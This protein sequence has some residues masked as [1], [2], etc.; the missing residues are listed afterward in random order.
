MKPRNRDTSYTAHSR[1]DFPALRLVRS[2][3]TPA[4][5]ARALLLMF[6]LFAL[7]LAF[8]P[9]Q[10]SV[11][12]DG[13]VIAFTPLERQ[14]SIQAPLEGRIVRWWVQ[15]GARVAAGDRLLEISDN[16]PQLLERITGEINAIKDKLARS[17]DRA[18]TVQ[19]RIRSLTESKSLGTTAAQARVQ[20]AK[21]RQAA[22]AQALDASRA[23]DRA[24]R[25]NLERQH[26]LVAEG[27]ASRR[28]DELAELEAAQRRTDV[29][30]MLASVSAANNELLALKADQGKVGTDIGAII[31]SARAD[32][33]KALEDVAHSEGEL[34]RVEVRRSRQQSQVLVAPRAGTVLRQLVGESAEMVKAGDPLL[35]L[36]PDTEQRAVEMWVDGND[37]PLISPGRHV[38]LQ[39]EGWPAIQ[40]SGWPSVAVGTFG[41]VVS[42]VDATDNGQGDFRIVVSP[43]S[44]E[45]WPDIRYLRQG[46]HAKGWVLLNR[47]RLGFELWRRFNG[48][49]PVILHDVHRADAM[50]KKAKSA[51][52]AGQGFK[53]GRTDDSKGKESP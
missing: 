12:G 9:W 31:E 4:T 28:A 29:D 10:Q 36:V 35:V 53:D 3:R 33:A 1:D 37:A 42:F 14:Q 47:V 13:R 27:L 21:D 16:D 15:E 39:F 52:R 38:R 6:C 5:V 32:Y 48:F 46:V 20:M 26:K 22:A 30:R 8:V 45:Q 40:F 17:K 11:V 34:N 23:A 43:D 44:T 2:R 49:P 24:A 19:D 51:G 25:L 7:S 50:E 18:A 41:G